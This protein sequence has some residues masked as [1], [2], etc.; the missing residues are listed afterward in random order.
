MPPAR[1]GPRPV[2]AQ[3]RRVAESDREQ[4][5]AER[6]RPEPAPHAGRFFDGQ[7]DV[8]GAGAGPLA[9][10]ESAWNISKIGGGGAYRAPLYTDQPRAIAVARLALP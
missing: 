5:H 7:R 6:H 3:P 8:Q 2:E 10:T 9:S 4:G 1:H